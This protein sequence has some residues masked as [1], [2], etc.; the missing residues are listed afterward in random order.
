MSLFLLKLKISFSSVLEVLLKWQYFIIALVGY[1]VA[2]A[3]VLWSLNVDLVKYILFDSGVSISTKFEFFFSVYRDIF[4]NY[5]SAQALVIIFF[6]LLFGI[7][8]AL[9]VF[10]LKNQDYRSIPKKSG[11]GG[12]IFA[13]I[14][15]GCLACGTSILYPLLITLG[16][17]TSIVAQQIGMVLSIIG[18]IFLMFSIYK[19]GGVASFVLK[20]KEQ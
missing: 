17:S 4:T 18:S 1:L 20:S 11:F 16:L 13:V 14:G 3:M 6:S 12:L 7:N 15:G 19:L 8:T 10:V 5:E 2:E 9:V